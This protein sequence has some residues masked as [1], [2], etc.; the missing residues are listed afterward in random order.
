MFGRGC[1]LWFFLSFLFLSLS[2]SPAALAQL[3][4]DP[5]FQS[6]LQKHLAASKNSY[7][8]Y[9]LNIIIIIYCVCVC[10]GGGGD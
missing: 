3:S 7:E 10:G 1:G 6:I 5:K 2:L 4:K 9:A 8:K